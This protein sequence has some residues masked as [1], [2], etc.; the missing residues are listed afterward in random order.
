[1]KIYLQGKGFIKKNIAE[2][3]LEVEP[4]SLLGQLPVLL[5]L[6]APHNLVYLVNGRIKNADSEVYDGDRIIL[7]SKLAGG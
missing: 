4:G 7:I 6:P 3:E 1:V 2:T 5:N